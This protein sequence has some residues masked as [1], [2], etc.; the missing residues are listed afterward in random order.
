VFQASLARSSSSLIVHKWSL[1]P[2]A[3]AGVLL[4]S[5]SFVRAKLYHAEKGTVLPWVLVLTVYAAR[6]YLPS[7]RAFSC[8]VEC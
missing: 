5:V 4:F 7:W 3:I 6:H 8:A 1:N 2:L